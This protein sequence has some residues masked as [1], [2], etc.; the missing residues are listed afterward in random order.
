MSQKHFVKFEVGDV[1]NI[2][3]W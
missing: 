3:L 1:H 2:F